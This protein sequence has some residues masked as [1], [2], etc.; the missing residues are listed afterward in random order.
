MLALFA[1]FAIAVAQAAT[2]RV[3]PDAP[4]GG[5]GLSWET[6]MTIDEA[7]TKVL[8]GNVHGTVILCKAGV[9]VPQSTLAVER[10]I[11]MK[12]GLA[13]TDDQTLDPKG[14]RTVIDGNNSSGISPIFD[15]TAGDLSVFERIEIRN[16]YL[17]GFDK[18]G[19]GDILFRDCVF[20]SCGRNYKSGV[21][22]LRGG[23]GRFRGG[24]GNNTP[25]ASITFE[26]CV[27]SQ[28]MY[29][30]NSNAQIGYGV[31]VAFQH[32]K[33][34][35]IDN[36]L[37]VS[38]GLGRACL[39]STSGGS[40]VNNIRGAAIYSES[41]VTIRNTEFRAN[42]T[43]INA[44]LGGIVYI[45][46]AKANSA[47]TNCL[48]LA[49]S[50][51]HCNSDSSSKEGGVVVF[52][53]KT[54]DVLDV[55]NCTFAYNFT[56]SKHNASAG[57]DVASD[58][59]VANIKNTIFYGQQKTE[60]LQCG[61][62]ICVSSG[63]TANIDYCLFEEDSA[64]CISGAGTVAKGENNVFGDPK[65]VRA[66]AADEIASVKVGGNT[67]FGYSEDSYE[68]VFSKADVH[69]LNRKLTVDTG[70]PASPWEKE[71]SPNGKRANLGYYGN[72]LE[73]LGTI[74]GL[75]IMFR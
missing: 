15:I 1:V 67:Y 54:S 2:Y 59:S 34:V 63:C 53:S 5:N 65:F 19:R 38:N 26:N 17:R 10:N 49:N 12:G 70:D 60:Y 30:E 20:D 64:T 29:E 25:A 74:N 21:S 73:A 37:F 22:S 48:F 47:M 51:E 42:R 75:T 56:A 13:G 33:R 36:C 14:G 69:A 24:D 71:P 3:T 32:C 40:G 68:N 52:R 27:F 58:N 41:P 45:K 44:A 6:P 66:I 4:G 28:N 9:Y 35:T 62:D 11:T 46:E 7:I 72:T 43:G 16:A 8:N 18:S 61:K 57:I 39:K 55:V 31:A 50:C 23:A